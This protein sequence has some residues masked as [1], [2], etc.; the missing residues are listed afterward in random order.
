MPCAVQ[1][2]L[3]VWSESPT[4]DGARESGAKSGRVKSAATFGV[5]N[6]PTSDYLIYPCLVVAPRTARRRSTWTTILPQYLVEND[7]ICASLG[8]QHCQESNHSLLCLVIY[9]YLAYLGT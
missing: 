3:G 4:G 9:T 1:R 7:R 2:C 5:T 6:V 8:L